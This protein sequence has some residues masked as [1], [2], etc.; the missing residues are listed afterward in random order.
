MF[1]YT[2]TSKEAFL[3]FVFLWSCLLVTPTG[4]SLQPITLQPAVLLNGSCTNVSQLLVSLTQNITSIISQQVSANLSCI[5]NQGLG[6]SALCAANSCQAIAVSMPNYTS[7]YYWIVNSTNS[8]IQVY[9]DLNRV[10]NGSRGWMRVAYVNMTDAA[11]S[12]PSTWSLYT[13]GTFRL[14]GRS[15]D[16]ICFSAFFLSYGVSYYKV[17]G[18]IRGYNYNSNDGFNRINCPSPCTIDKPYVDGVSITYNNSTGSRQHLW[19]YTSSAP[20]GGSCPCY[21]GSASK[22]TT[23]IPSFVGSNW[24][25]QG[26]D[27]GNTANYYNYP[28]WG[29]IG[30]TCTAGNQVPCCTN[31]NLPWFYQTLSAPAISNLEVRI[32]CDQSRT[33][34]DVRLQNVELYVT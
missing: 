11:Q 4:L 16:N 20:S 28:L 13:P 5:L 25:C 23:S 19:T 22:F 6:L 8:A 3:L 33:D 26:Q 14:C 2:T 32:C 17:C 12:C 24:Y 31:P 34:E 21:T 29:G 7:G 9:C 1:M 15:A 10:L 27:A 18:W 30:S